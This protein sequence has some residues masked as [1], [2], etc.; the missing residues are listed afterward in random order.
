M[1]MDANELARLRAVA[2]AATPG[3][4]KALGDNQGHPGGLEW[5]VS[6]P[7]LEDDDFTGW[8]AGPDGG[9]GIAN[10]GLPGIQ[11]DA[12][13]IATFDPPT[14]LA[15]LDVLAE[16]DAVP[17]W[18]NCANGSPGACESYRCGSNCSNTYDRMHPCLA[19]MS[20]DYVE[21]RKRADAALAPFIE[22]AK[23]E[24]LRDAAAWFVSEHP[25][26]GSRYRAEHVERD[27]RTRADA[28]EKESA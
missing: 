15:L 8:V 27:L 19:C 6:A 12:T 1:S 25:W 3:P 24:A 11:A 13:H 9:D 20:A 18:T 16:K 14:V 17:D 28:I 26:P 2:L 10:T 5:S 23:A 7:E 4:W 21:E 22:R